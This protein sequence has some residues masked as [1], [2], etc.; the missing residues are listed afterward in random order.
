VSFGGG[1]ATLALL[2]Q[3]IVR[4]RQ[5]LNPRDFAFG[6]GISRMYPGVHL[7]AQAVVIG[8]WLRGLAGSAVCLTAMMLPASVITI[9]F[10]A[11]FVTVRENRIGAAVIEGL[12]PATGGLTLA[13][14]YA[15]AQGEL[16]G[17][18]TLVQALSLLLMAMCFVLMAGLGIPSAIGVLLCGAIGILLYRVPGWANGSD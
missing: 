15:L 4:K 6:L 3:E 12:L 17:R 9:L 18:P 5:W 10:T 14:A 16:A 1:S 2:Q 7:L 8:F 13:V 11:F